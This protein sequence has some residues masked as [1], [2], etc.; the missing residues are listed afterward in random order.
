MDTQ[1]VADQFGISRRRVQQLAK[2]YRDTG[3]MPTVQTPGRKPYATYPADLEARILELFDQ[4]EQGA[5]AIAHI[6]RSRDD[7][8]IDTN[9]V[10]EILKEHQHVTDNP[11]KRRRQ[12]PWVRWERDFS[13]VTVHLDW[14]QNDRGDWCL[15][16]GDDASRTV[17]GMIETAARF[18]AK[19]VRL[20][21]KV[22]DSQAD[23]G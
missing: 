22:R 4:H 3:E 20:L 17:L 11:N 7:I 8:S 21:D 9:H 14:Y 10:H 1:L 2:E 16:V 5:E 15:A 18:S 6:L 13:L 12:R 23:T 19:S